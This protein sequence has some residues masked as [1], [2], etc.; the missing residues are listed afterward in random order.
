L[1]TNWPARIVSAK[2]VEFQLLKIRE[3]G[4]V[5]GGVNVV[6]Q[7]K[8]CVYYYFPCWKDYSIGDVFCDL[9]WV[10][11]SSLLPFVEENVDLEGIPQNAKKQFKRG[12]T[13]A[14]GLKYWALGADFRSPKTQSKFAKGTNEIHHSVGDYGPILNIATEKWLETSKLYDPVKIVEMILDSTQNSNKLPKYDRVRSRALRANI[15]G[16]FLKPPE[17]ADNDASPDD[18]TPVKQEDDDDAIV[19]ANSSKTNQKGG[20]A[21]TIIM[22]LNAIGQ[23]FS[24]SCHSS[25]SK[26]IFNDIRTLSTSTPIEDVPFHL[27]ITKLSTRIV[28]LEEEKIKL[29]RSLAD[30]KKRRQAEVIELD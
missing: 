18:G 6:P 29:A 3:S 12:W 4:C 22:V 9:T 7:G 24:A 11:E 27:I 10:D 21:E 1:Y 19:T 14:A 30:K 2:E 15:G 25:A 23:T 13:V 17:R 26:E 8:V 16:S 28:E 20:G 5:G